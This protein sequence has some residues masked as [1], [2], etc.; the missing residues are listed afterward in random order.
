MCWTAVAGAREPD[1]GTP[2]SIHSFKYNGSLVV[3]QQV[4]ISWFTMAADECRLTT[5]G[6]VYDVSDAGSKTVTVTDAN[7]TSVLYCRNRYGST[8]KSI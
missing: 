2:P 4:S 7:M 1:I 6:S 8:E 3:G 5:G